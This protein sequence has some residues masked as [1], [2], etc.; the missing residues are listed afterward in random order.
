MITVIEDEEIELRTKNDNIIN[1]YNIYI[2]E[3]NELIGYI[4]YRGYHK[5]V[6]LGDIGSV[7]YPKYRGHGFAAKALVLLSKYLNE[8]NIADFWIT[9]NENNIPSK[10][11]IEKLAQKNPKKIENDILLYEC[12]TIEKTKTNRK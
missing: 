11:T 6:K 1:S 2:K 5:D 3:T 4:I 8:N 7:I 10:K 12:Q 9:C